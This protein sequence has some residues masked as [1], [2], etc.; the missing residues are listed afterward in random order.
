MLAQGPA[1]ELKERRDTI[2]G[3][4]LRE[5]LK[6][7]VQPRR[8][9]EKSTPSVELIGARL[10]NLKDVDVRFPLGRLSVVTG[11]SGSGKS[12]L[13]RDV[14]HENLHRLVAGERNAKP[15]ER[16]SG[17][18]GIKGWEHVSR[19]LEVDQTP[20]GKTPRS[21]PATY[22]GFFDNIRRLFADTQEARIP[23]YTATRLSF[24]TKG[25]RC[26]RCDGQGA[27]TIPMSFLP[28]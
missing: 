1:E 25:G 8:P 18:K 3:H 4:F 20:I 27:K 17:A 12:T 15:G 14:L 19:V 9:V 2:P 26:A 7:P 10:H 23:G 5:P 28:D 13:A 24:N 11:V 16:I 21:C 22:V 6:H